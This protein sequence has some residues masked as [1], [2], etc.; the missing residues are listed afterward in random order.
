[1]GEPTSPVLTTGSGTE[2]EGW[3]LVREFV[4]GVTTGPGQ[5]AAALDAALRT[6]ETRGY[7]KAIA[8]LRNVFTATFDRAADFLATRLSSTTG[9]EQAMRRPRMWALHP[10]PGP[11]V[12]AVI[13]RFG[14]RFERGT[15]YN[16]DGTEEEIWF[17]TLFASDDGEEGWEEVPDLHL[18]WDLLMRN[19]SPLTD[20]SGESRLTEESP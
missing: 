5:R 16:D 18:P 14:Q 3:E 9:F 17:G 20:A 2:E 4:L 19:H 15:A 13:D 1:M 8:D 6:V 7:R 12:T 11:E 10:E